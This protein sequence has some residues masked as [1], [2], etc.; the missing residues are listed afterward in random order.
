VLFDFDGVIADTENVHIA[1][2]ER[3]FGRM[4]WDV[5]PEVCARAAEIDDRQFL[6]EVFA[7]H[8]IPDGDIEGWIR[9]KQQLA[10]GLLTDAPR[11]YPGVAQLVER[12][13][14]RVRLAVVSG[15]WRENVEIVLRAARLDPAFPVIVGKEDVSEPKPDPAAYRVAL[16][17]L[18]VPPSAAVAIED[19]PTG[20]ASARGAGLRAVAVGHRRSA[21]EWSQ[22]VP[23]L[24]DLRDTEA[25]LRELGL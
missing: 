17:R 11:V 13:A 21:G 23:F 5:S 15:T 3:T 16:K 6:R 18:G 19:S 9:Q 20:L 25:V 2:W 12:L 7:R 1:A 4:G 22:G 24:A 14:G 8:G 10:L